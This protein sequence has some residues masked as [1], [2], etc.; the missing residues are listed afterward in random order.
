[1][2]V[3]ILERVAR[4]VRGD[5]SRWLIEV[6]TGVFVGR[7]TERVREAL[8]SRAV[9]RSGEGSVLMVWRAANE[10]GFDLR[11]HQA[12]GRFPVDYEGMWLMLE[13]DPNPRFDAAEGDE[14]DTGTDAPDGVI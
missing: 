4:S 2:T 10:Q 14:T 5:L 13:P 8:W 9:K 3:L 6:R 1:M 7:V 12:K 11:A